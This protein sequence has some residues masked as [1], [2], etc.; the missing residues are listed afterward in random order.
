MAGSR[1][2]MEVPCFF[3]SREAS[4]TEREGR[5]MAM[6][7]EFQRMKC[8]FPGAFRGACWKIRIFFHTHG[9]YIYI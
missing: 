1:L 2:V 8:S 4:G 9:I 3:S 6:N 7:R 5:D